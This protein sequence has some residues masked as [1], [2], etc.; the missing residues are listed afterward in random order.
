MK[1]EFR[2]SFEKD[3]RKLRDAS[4]LQRIKAAIEEVE[5][6]ESLETVSN[7]SKL[8]AEGNHYRIKI[9]DYRIG[10]AVQ[11]NS[12]DFIRVLHRKEIYRYFP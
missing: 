8:K 12:V 6:A 1:V 7:L 5:S 4:L 10:I 2:K 3:L 9:G 11:S